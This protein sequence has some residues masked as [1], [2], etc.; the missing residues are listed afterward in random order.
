MVDFTAMFCLLIYIAGLAIVVLLLPKD[1]Q[2]DIQNDISYLF[3]SDSDDDENSEGNRD[4]TMLKIPL[5]ESV[6]GNIQTS[7]DNHFIITSD[8]ASSKYYLYIKQGQE[9]NRLS[10][11]KQPYKLLQDIQNYEKRNM[12]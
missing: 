11:S 5:T 2:K 7:K 1:I 6:W 12:L 10:S 3:K 9:Y 4:M 8:V